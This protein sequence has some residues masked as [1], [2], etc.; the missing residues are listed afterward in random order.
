M[1]QRLMGSEV[2]SLSAVFGG[3]VRGVKEVK[4]GSGESAGKRSTVRACGAPAV[5]SCSLPCKAETLN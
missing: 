2:I 5:S 4:M 3:S 1:L